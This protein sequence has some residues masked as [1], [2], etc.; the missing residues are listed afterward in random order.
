[1]AFTEKKDK[2]IASLLFLQT[3]PLMKLKYY[4]L[5]ILK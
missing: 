1:M 3:I 4:Y 2:M 5:F